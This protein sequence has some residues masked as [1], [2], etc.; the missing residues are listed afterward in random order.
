MKFVF[1]ISKN[2]ILDCLNII[3]DMISYKKNSFFSNNIEN[4][5]IKKKDSILPD[6][7]SDKI[8][9]D[10]KH[11]SNKQQYVFNYLLFIFDISH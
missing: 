7:K 10:T 9:K 4:Y 1:V 6:C 5:N 3:S 8:K 2:L 11:G